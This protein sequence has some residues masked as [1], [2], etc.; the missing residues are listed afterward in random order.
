MVNGSFTPTGRNVMTVRVVSYEDGCIKG[1]LASSECPDETEFF[2]AIPLIIA[3]EK[4]MDSTNTPQR[5]EEPRNF[6]ISAEK[7]ASAKA[8]KRLAR[9]G[10]V[11]GTFQIYVLF[12]QNAT[13][14]GRLIWVEENMEA[15]FRSV[16]ELLRL[17]D[18]A[19]AK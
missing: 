18:S 14:Q 1:L 19:L 10:A 7:K 11:L 4:I 13:W 17:L 9:T 15:S 3:M 12:R 2:G 6:A 5:G 8:E 16:L